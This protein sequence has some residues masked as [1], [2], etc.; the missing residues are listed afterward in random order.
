MQFNNKV[1]EE[2]GTIFARLN[3]F[4]SSKQFSG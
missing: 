1:I 3:F 2:D 4:G